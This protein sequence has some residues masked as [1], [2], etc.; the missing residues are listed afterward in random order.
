MINQTPPT[1]PATP[2]N[3]K[4]ADAS[5]NSASGETVKQNQK[6]PQDKETARETIE[7]VVFAF[8]LA[9]LFRTYA[10]EAFVIPTG[11]M[12]PTLYGRHKEVKCEVSGDTYQFG[13]SS[14]ILRDGNIVVSRIQRALSPN[15]RYS[16]PR[17]YD[18]P[19]YK[20]DRILVNKFIYEM[21]D[22][23]R[24]DVVVFKYPEDAKTNY[25]KRLIGL[26]GETIRIQGGNVYRLGPNQR[27]EILRK[28][29]PNKQQEIQ[30][31]V[32]D[33]AYPAKKLHEAGWPQRW[34]AV[35]QDARE[36]PLTVAGWTERDDSWQPDLKKRTYA[37]GEAQSQ[38]GKLHWM[39]YRHFVPNQQTWE[40]LENEDPLE[41]APRLI[42]DFC[43]YN[44][45]SDN[46]RFP[47]TDE[48]FWVGDLTV[49][50]KIQLGSPS[51]GAE[52]VLELTE[53]LHWYRCRLDPNTGAA[54]LTQVDISLAPDDEIE[55]A[56]A[57]TRFKGAGKYTFRFANVDDR[58]CLW[59]NG[60]LVDFGS[61]AEYESSE[62]HGALPHESDYTPVGIAVQG[63]TATV[64]NLLLERDIYYR[65]HYTSN[66]RD[67]LLLSNV[68]EYR[69]AYLNKR[70]EWDTL[71]YVIPE[72]EYFVL[73][74]NSPRSSDSRYWESTHTV[75]RESFVGKAFFIYWPH[76]IPIGL[77]SRW[78]IPISYHK[79][80]VRGELITDKEYPLHYVPFYPNFA[81]MKRIR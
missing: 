40:R 46:I 73:G 57:N 1:S 38:D 36:T 78:A 7:S 13:A 28:T 63:V 12:A 52:V 70:K 48:V 20:G 30:I 34:A 67:T 21:Q 54:R 8:V 45:T 15:D 47:E 10:A 68:E 31:P 35:Q 60:R 22:P 6:P 5:A 65:G 37:L 33:D 62:V 55:M 32:Y 72:G 53:G 74:D 75:P 51:P 69:K 42:G 27:A 80:F 17:A 24:F 61:G 41:P 43:G 50:G 16:D 19:V 2:P 44:T 18:A 23:Q 29:D 79:R 76:G 3:G 39:R 14:E 71:E 11:S 9:F 77:D 64:S 49:S 66:E 4:P 58:L 81:R 59:I 56:R 25:I 26:P